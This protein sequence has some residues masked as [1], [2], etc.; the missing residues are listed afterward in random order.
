[1]HKVVHI[2]TVHNP[3]DT[4]IYYKM[5]ETVAN[6]DFELFYIVKEHNDLKKIVERSNFHLRVLKKPRGRFSRMLKTAVEAL[7]V[8]KKLDADIYHIHDPE[9]LW[10]GSLLKTK[11]NI[12]IY[13]VH[14]DYETSI[15]QKKY[16]YKP[17]RKVIASIFNVYEKTMSRKM[18]KC[19]AE[20]YYSNK[21]P[22]GKHILNYPILNEASR[23]QDQS[24]NSN[25]Q[26]DHKIR[27]IYTGTVG[28]DRGALNHAKLTTFDDNFEITSVG[29][30]PYLLAEKIYNTAGEYKKNIQMVGVE[31]YI[32]RNVIDEYYLKNN[33]VAGLALFPHTKHYEQKELTKFFEYMSF[34]IPILCSDFPVWKKF[35]DKH[36]CGISVNPENEAE[37]K[38]AIYYLVKNPKEAKKMGENG[39]KA[40]AAELNWEFEGKKLIDWY[41]QLIDNRRK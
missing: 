20:K 24:S 26:T 23:L 9:L 6:N 33:W 25:T 13:D 36:Q 7:K 14:E 3:L 12:V 2:T 8:A 19:L 21:F 40:I 41:D 17:F 31:E 39:K 34:G 1:M 18:E 38:E 28:L 30:C 15:K 5:C 35:I 27:L 37:I 10:V 4:R 22:N 29:K 11:H 32:P 16:I